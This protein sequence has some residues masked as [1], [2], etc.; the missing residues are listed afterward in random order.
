M[1][2][3]TKFYITILLAFIAF[4]AQSQSTATSSSP[5]S[6]YGLGD[7]S[8]T[9]IMPQNI[10]MGGIATATNNIGAFFNINSV[11]PASYA[12]LKFTV[13]DI[14][15][16]ENTLFLSQTGQ[17]TQTNAN[18]RLSHVAF[19]IPITS[20]SGLSFGLQPYSQLGYNYIQNLPRGFGTGSPADTNSTN[21]IYKGEGGL[22]KAYLGYGITILKHL[23]L[24]ANVSYIF[25]NLKQ[26]QSTEIPGLYGTLNS[27]AEQNNAIG[28]LNYDYG[29]QY[30]IDLKPQM[31][32]TLGYAASANS[33]LNSQ[34]TYILSQYTVDGSGNAS[35]AID[36]VIVA[37]STKTKLQLPQIN[38]YGVSL[39]DGEKYLIGMDYTTGKWSNL[40]IGGVNQGLLDSKTYNIGGQYTPNINA[41]NNYWAT[42]DYRLGFMYD[43]S[44]LNV[45][46]PTG[47]G[48]TN[49]KSYALTMGLG[50]PLKHVFTAS[51][52]AYKINLALELGQRGTVANGL[53]KENY[54]NFHLGFLLNDKWFQRIKFD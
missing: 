29:A 40:T 41:I 51:H 5:Y 43:Q 4:S 24:G 15:I 30:T 13:I 37:P 54:V 32:L 12:F 25:G 3:F 8:S 36:S 17:S 39:T 6:R 20:N 19:G 14:G 27:T 46:N 21:Y 44:F 50:V 18:F 48:S 52:S 34:S 16:Y 11:N 22:S 38:H 26:T 23:S 28:G 9:G 2:K 33:Q 42:V 53:V 7:I 49:I 10:A 1:I 47:N 45:P 31:R 35:S